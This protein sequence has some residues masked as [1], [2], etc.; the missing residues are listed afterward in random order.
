MPD[1]AQRWSRPGNPRWNE[2]TRGC[3]GA[4]AMNP[5]TR[6]LRDVIRPSTRRNVSALWAMSVLNALLFFGIFM[7]VLPGLAHL[8]LPWAIPIPA[9]LRG[10]PAAVLGIAGISGWIACLDAFSRHGRGTPLPADA[11]RHLV[12][13]GLFALSRNPIMASELM[14]IWA[15]AWYVASLGIVLYAI[16]I[17]AAAHLAVVHV[18]EP[19]LAERFG[20][21]YRRYCQEVPRWFPRLRK[22]APRAPG[23]AASD[24]D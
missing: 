7:V 4:P 12:T 17:T 20:E 14:V 1:G 15:E 22:I 16:A 18:E 5:L 9:G 21:A 19:E 2:R 24:D 23:T 6:L 13:T 3:A 8:A 10:V 11:P